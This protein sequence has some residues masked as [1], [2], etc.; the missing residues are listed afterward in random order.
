MAFRLSNLGEERVFKPAPDLHTVH[1]LGMGKSAQDF[2]NMVFADRAF[3]KRKGEQVWTIN[4]G[5]FVYQH[6]VSFNMHD[7]GD[8]VHK[9]VRDWY[10]EDWP[11]P[12]VTCRALED[13][14]NTFEYPLQEVMDE[15]KDSYFTNGVSYMIAIAL[16]AFAKST[17]E[18]KVKTLTFWGCDY[19]YRSDQL[20]QIAFEHGRPNVE[21]WIGKAKARGVN[22]WSAASSGLLDIP[23][24]MQH[25]LYGYDNAHPIME[26]CDDAGGVALK[27]FKDLPPSFDEIDAKVPKT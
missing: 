8:P 27:G 19:E 12:V 20:K 3:G 9:W 6:H 14:Q 23:E 26:L 25:G 1:I 16:I 2:N 7:L 5:G 24:R 17:S 15:F 4:A 10:P 22:I 11:W 13:V 21:Y 18:K